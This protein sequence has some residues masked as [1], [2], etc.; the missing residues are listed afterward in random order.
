[1]KLAKWYPVATVEGGIASLKISQFRFN[2][3]TRNLHYGLDL[4]WQTRLAC[5]Q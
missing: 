4:F 2:I 1:M 3:R 5:D